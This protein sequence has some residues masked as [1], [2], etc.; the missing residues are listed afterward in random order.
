MDA[1][2][3]HFEVFK[4]KIAA[5]ADFVEV[6]L[7]QVAK[8]ALGFQIQAGGTFKVERHSV[9]EEWAEVGKVDVAFEAGVDKHVAHE[10]V[11]RAG[12]TKV[13]LAHTGIELMDL[14]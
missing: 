3:T 13:R 1:V 12:D 6:D 14:D 7:G 8:A 2:P 9:G 10:V 5:K 4:E 11:D